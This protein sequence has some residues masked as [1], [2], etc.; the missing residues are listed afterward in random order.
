MLP[1]LCCRARLG[2]PEAPKTGDALAA[3]G[4]SMGGFREIHQQ[5]L[6]F[7]IQKNR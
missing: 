7:N 2:L 1:C 3:P 5:D 6:G 4:G